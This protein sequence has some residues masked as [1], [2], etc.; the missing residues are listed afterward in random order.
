[1]SPIDIAVYVAIGAAALLPFAGQAVQAAKGLL[2][3]AK[4]E[5]LAD[6]WTRGWADA[7]IQ[8]IE[9]IEDGRMT[10]GNPEETQQ[11]AR[12]LIWHLIGGEVE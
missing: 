12:Q 1:M 10:V 3:P 11:L 5:P 7:M 8:L 6:D 2:T 9:E 4:P